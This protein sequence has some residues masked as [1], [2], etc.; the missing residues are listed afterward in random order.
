LNARVKRAANSERAAREL[1]YDSVAEY[2]ER[3]F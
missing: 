3:K 1:H 2:R